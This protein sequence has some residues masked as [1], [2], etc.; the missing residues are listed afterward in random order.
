MQIVHWCLG[1][2]ILGGLALCSV[3]LSIVAVTQP[4]GTLIFWLGAGQLAGYVTIVTF[5]VIAIR[6]PAADDFPASAF[7]P[8]ASE[9]VYASK[10]LSR[11]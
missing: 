7:T 2:I 1:A 9:I 3:A 8:I 6:R 5:V 11:N 10:S 4:P